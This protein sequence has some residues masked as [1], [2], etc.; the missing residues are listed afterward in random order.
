MYMFPSYIKKKFRE[1]F[2]AL[3]IFK[4]FENIFLYKYINNNTNCEAFFKE[5]FTTFHTKVLIFV[6]FLSAFCS[7]IYKKNTS[8]VQFSVVFL[9]LDCSSFFILQGFSHL[10][11]IIFKVPET[12]T[13]LK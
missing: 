4:R 6:H 9:L 12:N 2:Q 5:L 3:K 11:F 8:K 13:K 10:K 7:F 1:I